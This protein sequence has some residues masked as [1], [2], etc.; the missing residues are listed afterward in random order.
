MGRRYISLA[1]PSRD[2]RGD[3][4]QNIGLIIDLL[5]RVAVVLMELKGWG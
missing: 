2:V 4:C 1:P 3:I 5:L